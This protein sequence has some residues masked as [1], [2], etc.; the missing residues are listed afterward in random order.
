MDDFKVILQV[1]NSEINFY[2]DKSNEDWSEDKNEDFKL[3]I[4]YCRDLVQ[5]II[6]IQA[7]YIAFNFYT[8]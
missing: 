3:G 2:S 8:G 7:I 1:L 4:A 5:N 6:N